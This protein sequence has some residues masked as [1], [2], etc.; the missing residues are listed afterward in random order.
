M[1]NHKKV[2]FARQKGSH[3]KHMPQYGKEL[4]FSPST[5]ANA[6]KKHFANLASDLVKRL[7]EPTG[8]FGIPSVRHYKQKILTSL[9]K[10]LKF[11]KVSSVLVLKTK[12]F[13][14]SRATGVDNLAEK[15]LKDGLNILCAPIVRICNLSIKFA[16]FPD[17]CKVAKIKRWSQN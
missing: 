7:P 13:K 6:F 10:Q 1:K 14:T 8:K 3:N 11:E 12:E 17:K 16:S 5:I 15:F 2:G 9:K 4:T